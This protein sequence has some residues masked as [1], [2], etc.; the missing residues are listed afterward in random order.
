MLGAGRDLCVSRKEEEEEDIVLHEREVAG[1]EIL[2]MVGVVL[3]CYDPVS[4]PDTCE[5]AI[6]TRLRLRARSTRLCPHWHHFPFLA[7]PLTKTN[8]FALGT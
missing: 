6:H 8:S 3:G 4:V 7:H 5:L 2:V 1:H